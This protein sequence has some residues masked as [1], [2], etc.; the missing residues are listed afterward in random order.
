MNSELE[1]N[2]QLN[3]SFKNFF[4]FIK[5]KNYLTKQIQK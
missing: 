5:Q 4:F 3:K 1:L 2:L